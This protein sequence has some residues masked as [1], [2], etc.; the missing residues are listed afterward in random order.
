MNIHVSVL[1]ALSSYA[2]YE[3]QIKV[4]Q[5]AL[6]NLPFCVQLISATNNRQY[7]MFL[8]YLKGPSH[9]VRSA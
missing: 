4:K 9:Q 1:A 6:L 8:F 3:K 2:N 7:M 5:L